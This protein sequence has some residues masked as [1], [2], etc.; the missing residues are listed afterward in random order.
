MQYRPELA[1]QDAACPTCGKIFNVPVLQQERQAAIPIG[2]SVH[3]G[4]SAENSL[5]GGQA[6]PFEISRTQLKPLPPEYAH[7]RKD[8]TGVH[9]RKIFWVCML[10]LISLIGYGVSIILSVLAKT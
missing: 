10:T 6:S 7:L 2:D 8:A 9:N 3:E 1:G 4:F 5:Q